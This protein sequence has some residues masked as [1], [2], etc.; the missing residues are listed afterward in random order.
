MNRRRA[1]EPP[2]EN[3]LRFAH[4]QMKN[5]TA[6]LLGLIMMCV[7]AFVA[8]SV[9]MACGDTPTPYVTL[10]DLLPSA[11]SGLPREAAIVLRGKLWGPSGGPFTFADVRLFDEAGNRIPAVSLSWY[12]AEPSLALR[13]AA[14]LPAR[15]KF[16]VEAVV[17]TGT[18]K[19]PGA[20]GPLTT[21]FALETGDELAP[22]MVLAGPLRVQL[23]RFD[24]DQLK[25]EG[26]AF[27]SAPVCKKIGTQRALR[28]RLFIPAATGGEDFDGYRGWLRFTD[29]SPATFNGSGE[30]RHDSGNVNVMH[31]IDVRPGAETEIVQEIFD[32]EAPYA[33]CFALNLWDPAGHAVQA[34]PVCLAVMKPSDH[35]RELDRAP[36]AGGCQAAPGRGGG[37]GLLVMAV[38]GLLR[39][40]KRF[41]CRPALQADVGGE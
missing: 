16:I 8:P 20:E 38:F 19:P 21:R 37:P 6:G 2:R 29:N 26:S 22:P 9:A 3:G 25:C 7:T 27:C 41:N 35:V 17:P 14:P 39:R 40:V 30:G 31:W 34:Q 32:E 28:A 5:T 12:S 36:D 1:K 33:P 13:P 15:T 4:D 24:R 11:R 18:A 23:E 10:G